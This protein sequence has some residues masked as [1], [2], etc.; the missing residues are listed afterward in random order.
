MKSRPVLLII[1]LVCAALP[2]AGEDGGEFFY[3]ATNPFGY[4]SFIPDPFFTYLV[5]VLTGGEYGVN[6]SFNWVYDD[7]NGFELRAAVGDPGPIASSYQFHLGYKLYLLDLLDIQENGFYLGAFLKA[8][9]QFY[10]FTGMHYFD[11][12]PCMT[13]GY[14]FRFG[15]FILDVRTLQTFCVMTVSSNSPFKPAF[16]PLFSTMPFVSPVLPLFS[17]NVGW[18]L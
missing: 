11:F 5:P 9:D 4:L 12:I 7:F 16:A 10:R 14:L 17:I 13:V 6:A 8:S 18:R 3:I 15:D 1:I 2:A